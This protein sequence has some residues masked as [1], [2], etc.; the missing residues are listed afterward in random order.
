LVAIA[1]PVG[2]CD[3]RPQPHQR[4]PQR[5]CS[6]RPVRRRPALGHRD[7]AYLPGFGLLNPS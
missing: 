7:H 1:I 3:P 2:W 5:G 6:L 4:G